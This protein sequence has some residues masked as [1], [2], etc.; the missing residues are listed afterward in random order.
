MKISSPIFRFVVLAG[1]ALLPLTAIPDATDPPSTE[2]QER[3]EVRLAQMA[4]LAKDRKGNPIDDLVAEEIVVKDRGYK[5]RVAFLEPFIREPG[6]EEIPDVRLF[7]A[8]PGSAEPTTRSTD[9]EPQYL[10][11]LVDVEH[12]YRLL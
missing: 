4:I 10:I 1:F 5:M 2:T 11:I 8:A 7:V 6:P 9:A 12:D 3:V